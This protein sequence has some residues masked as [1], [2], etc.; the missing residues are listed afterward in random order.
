MVWGGVLIGALG[1]GEGS[2]GPSDNPGVAA[3]LQVR[4]MWQVGGASEAHDIVVGAPPQSGAI[5]PRG[6]SAVVDRSDA[7]VILLDPE[8]GFAGSLG[9]SGPG[10]GEFQQPDE[11]GFLEDGLLWVSDRTGRITV[12]GQEGEIVTTISRP[13]AQVPGTPFS[14]RGKWRLAGGSVL[15]MGTTSQPHRGGEVMPR[16]LMIWDPDGQL[17]V[18]TELHLQASLSRQIRMES[19][20]VM[21]IAHPYPLRSDPIIGMPVGGGW[22]FALE[23]LPADRTADEGIIRIRRFDSLGR[24]IADDTI[25]Y[26]PRP[27][28]DSLHALLVQEAERM[29]AQL[30]PQLG[31]S[32]SA[33]L[34]ATWIPEHLPPVQQAF[35]DVDGYWLVREWVP[36][37]VT[38]WERYDLEAQLTGRLS[39]PKTFRGLAG[40]QHRLLG[41]ELDALGVPLVQMYEVLQS[42]PDS[43]AVR[44]QGGPP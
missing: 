12:F 15:G 30:P 17:N 7:T 41:W 42:P 39:L 14:V 19:G 27:V 20:Q 28:G 37:S 21:T 44:R 10:P 6:Y 11:S 38:L 24:L 26:E 33:I 31:V 2:P 29:A 36:E 1:C 34:E 35:A 9:S 32:S 5:G 13:S 16:P 3:E 25:L 18:V 23:R 40:T 43:G 22:F 4:R 8:G